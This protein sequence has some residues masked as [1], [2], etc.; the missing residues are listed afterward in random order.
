MN[1]ILLSLATL[2]A[3]A[4]I[5]SAQCTDV[6]ISKY[7]RFKGNTKAMEFYNTTNAPIDLTA[8]K[9]S[10]ERYKSI[11]ATGVIDATMDDS[12]YLV[13]TIPAL[14]TWVLVNG[15][16]AANSSATSPQ[17]DSSL[18]QIADQLDK[19]Y[20]TY[21]N[22]TIGQPMYFKG[23]DCMVLR[24]NGV[25]I[26]VFGEVNTTVTTA[27]SSIAP[28]RGASGM[29]KWI[30]TGYMMER[31][32]SVKEGRIPPIADSLSS[33]T[34]FNPLDQYDTIPKIPSVPTPTRQDTL[35]LFSLFGTHV[36]D[37]ATNGLKDLNIS[38][39]SLYPNPSTT[40]MAISAPESI[41]LVQIFNA[42]G[43]LVFTV[44]DFNSNIRIRTREF[45]AGIY[46]LKTTTES[47]KVLSNKAVFN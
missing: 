46:Q 32:A 24:K 13:G 2:L 10:I 18:Q 11:S 22:G 20:G 33:F 41:T 45:P 47:G 44:R 31:K 23:N 42:Q 38:K 6:I 21:G 34:E 15:Q 14:G 29:G 4:S 28:Y 12:L 16:N 27:W 37:C 3:A 25:I 19:Q 35:D 30:T 7:F 36:C 26:D 9:Y 8:G 40:E 1:R 39:A 43:E 5:A 17:P